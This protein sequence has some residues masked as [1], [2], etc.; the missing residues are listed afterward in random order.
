MNP[1]K[2]NAQ[3]AR[4]VNIIFIVLLVINIITTGSYFMQ[5]Q[6]LKSFKSGIND[7]TAAT[8]NDKR[9]SFLAIGYFTILIC[10]IIFFILWFRRAYNNLHV[11]QKVN[12]THS[13][14]W[15]TGAWFVPFLNLIRPYQIMEEI[16]SKTQEATKNLL[17]NKRS[18]I[19][20]WW[21]AIYLISNTA[22]NIANRLFNDDASFDDLISGTYAQIISNLIEI[23]SIILTIIMV[24]KTAEMEAKLYDSFEAPV[25]GQ[26]DLIGIV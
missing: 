20:G 17:S 14:G 1:L 5:L 24:K 11:T 19:V 3:R 6:L 21:W 10:T 4:G 8:A 2:N 23:P 18:T 25:E 26:E 12:L 9:V 7:L 16:W 15:A 13:E 22:N